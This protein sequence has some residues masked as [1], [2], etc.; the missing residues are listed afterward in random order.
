MK[1]KAAETLDKVRKRTCCRPTIIK[2][3][4]YYSQ[5]ISQYDPSMII[6]ADETSLTTNRRFL[7]VIGNHQF[8]IIENSKINT[9]IIHTEKSLK[10]SD[11]IIH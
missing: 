9:H 8:P 3:F 10:Y 4:S 7:I 2:F 11:N 1:I 6:N 5:I